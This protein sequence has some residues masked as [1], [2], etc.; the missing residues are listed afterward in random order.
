MFIVQHSAPTLGQYKFNRSR[1]SAALFGAGSRIFQEMISFPHFSLP[2]FGHFFPFLRRKIGTLFWL[3]SENFA[4]YQH[5]TDNLGLLFFLYMTAKYPK[6]T[7]V[8]RICSTFFIVQDRKV[9]KECS[10]DPDL[11]NFFYCTGPQST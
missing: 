5:C 7:A 3:P 1:T 6:K 8:T 2:H 11:F 10:R 4:S 9:S